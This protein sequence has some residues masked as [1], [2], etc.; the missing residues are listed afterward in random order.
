[1]T[2]SVSLSNIPFIWCKPCLREVAEVLVSGTFTD[3]CH[4]NVVIRK[5]DIDEILWVEKQHR[6]IPC[7]LTEIENKKEFHERQQKAVVDST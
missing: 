1:M 6:N 7:G 5:P 2:I 3:N 4:F